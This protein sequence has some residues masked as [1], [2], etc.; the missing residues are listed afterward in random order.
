MYNQSYDYWKLFT[1]VDFYIT[2]DVYGKKY[3]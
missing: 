1:R 3:K 2:R